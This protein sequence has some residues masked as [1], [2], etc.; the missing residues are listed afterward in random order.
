MNITKDNLQSE[1]QAYERY[2]K[3]DE[4][5]SKVQET[6]ELIEFYDEDNDCRRAV[7]AICEMVNRFIAKGKTAEPA[8]PAAS[9]DK[10]RRLKLLKLKAKAI[11]MKLELR[12]LDGIG[13]PTLFDGMDALDTVAPSRK[14][15][16]QMA[17]DVR[18]HFAKHWDAE[19]GEYVYTDFDGDQ[20]YKNKKGHFCLLNGA[21]PGKTRKDYEEYLNEVGESLSEDEFIIGGKMRRMPYGKALRKYS[22]I[23]FN[24]GYNEWKQGLGG[25]KGAKEILYV[26]DF[27]LENPVSDFHSAKD[28]LLEQT[29]M[30]TRFLYGDLDSLKLSRLNGK[31]KM[32]KWVLENIT[33]GHILLITTTELTENECAKISE[34]IKGQN[35]DG[36]GEHFE[37]EDFAITYDHYGDPQYASFDWRTNK[38]SLRKVSFTIDG[39]SVNSK[40]EQHA[41]DVIKKRYPKKDV[42]E[43]KEFVGNHWGEWP[44]DISD[45]E[46]V[47]LFEDWYFGDDINVL[48]D[49]FPD[50]EAEIQEYYNELHAWDWNKPR[51]DNLKAF[52]VW[53]DDRTNNV[54]EGGDLFESHWAYYGEKGTL[55]PLYNID[56][57]YGEDYDFAYQWLQEF[58]Q[59]DGYSLDR[60]W[61]NENDNTYGYLAK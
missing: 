11:K 20:W 26:A 43:I 40:T 60:L 41:I 14:A 42:G 58:L 57:L 24:A 36:I 51:Y 50:N 32:I 23:T 8:K 33:K 28:F 6:F 49:R 21:E 19:R 55:T 61:V 37:L 46:I 9:D 54:K 29:Y 53:L 4:M 18:E 3:D 56:N 25:T 16:R 10:E 15:Q 59:A 17:D 5:R 1:F 45:D 35:S 52:K 48:Y 7:D 38:Y 2:L 12:K 44:S 13:Q 39:V 22:P 30:Q 34:W 31:I 27:Y 47:E